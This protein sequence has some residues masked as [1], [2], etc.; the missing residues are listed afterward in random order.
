MKKQIMRKLKTL[1]HRLIPVKK[2]ISQENI[3]NNQD[4]QALR[5][6]P[7]V[8]DNGDNTHRINYDLNEA[9][10]VFDL[11]GYRGDWS[12][13]IFCRYNCSI[14]IF[15]PYQ[16]YFKKIK[17]RFLLNSKV[18]VFPFAL[19]EGNYTASIGI[20]DDKTSMYIQSNLKAEI[21]L[22]NIH[23]FLN[24]NNVLHID[25]MKINIEGGEFSLLEFLLLTNDVI[26][27]KNIQVQF[28]DLIP[29][30]EN[31][32][33]NIQCELSKTHELTYQY[34]FVWENW[35]LKEGYEDNEIA[36]WSR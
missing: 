26:K 30:A 31:R 15:E 27:I 11:G 32:M 6:I 12:A 18:K 34:E 1:K 22:R 4:K 2:N 23:D 8:N 13:Q 7:W 3:K 19:A 10:V 21:V 29:N 20:D 9:S 24:E 25:L 14:F 16:E 36:R 35:K 33:K 28:H 17:E 5:V